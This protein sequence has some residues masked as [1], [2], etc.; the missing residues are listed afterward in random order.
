[1]LVLGIAAGLCETQGI[2]LLFLRLVLRVGVGLHHLEDLDTFYHLHHLRVTID[3]ELGLP[4]LCQ[5]RLL[6][7]EGRSKGG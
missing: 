3:L 5:G 6:L 1:V 4:S 2:R 7:H